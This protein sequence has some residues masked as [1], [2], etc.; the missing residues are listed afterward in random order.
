MLVSYSEKDIIVHLNNYCLFTGENI[1][2]SSVSDVHT[3]TGSIKLFLRD[4]P[5]PLITYSAYPHFIS[6]M[7]GKIK[8]CLNAEKKFDSSHFF[9]TST[10]NQIVK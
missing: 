1:D 6:F 9:Q 10:V 2:F 3:I 5:I 7:S 8:I 4:L